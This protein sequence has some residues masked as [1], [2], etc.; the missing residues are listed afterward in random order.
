MKKTP[1]RICII[2]HK[3]YSKDSL[4]RIVLLNGE[5]CIDKTQ[6]MLGRGYYIAKTSIC[7]KTLIDKLSRIFKTSPS[8]TF[9]EELK[10][11]AK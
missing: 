7:S 4:L 11:Y 9:L 1:S 10:H 8:E 5:I 6:T 3:S 2:T